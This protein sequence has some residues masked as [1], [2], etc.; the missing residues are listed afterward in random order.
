MYNKLQLVALC[1]A[2][3][4]TVS[5]RSTKKVLGEALLDAIKDHTSIPFTSPVDDRIFRVAERSE[6]GDGH[7]RIRFSRGKYN[8]MTLIKMVKVF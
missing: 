4:V 8:V 3:N 6:S 1:N 5:A 2:Y 7:I